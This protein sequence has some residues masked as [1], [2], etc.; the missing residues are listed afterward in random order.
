MV[1]IFY[2]LMRL[3]VASRRHYPVSRSPTSMAVRSCSLTD[4]C[5]VTLRERREILRNNLLDLGPIRKCR[6]ARLCRC[7]VLCCHLSLHSNVVL[8]L[9]A[10][11]PF[12]RCQERI[13][14][15]RPPPSFSFPLLQA[16]LSLVHPL[17]STSYVLDDPAIISRSKSSFSLLFGIFFIWNDI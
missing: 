5:V 17:L 6:A 1:C 10:R 12:L 11:L 3:I 8:L 2:L 9:A 15:L 7:H 16:W 14:S 13:I 4:V